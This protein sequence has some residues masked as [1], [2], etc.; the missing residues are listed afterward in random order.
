MQRLHV[1]LTNRCTLECPACPRTTWKN[2]IKRSIKKADLDID[3]FGKFLDCQGGRQIDS[4]TLA[5][6]Y[7]DCIYYPNLIDFIQQFRSRYFEIHTN[8]SYKD[9]TFWK[10]LANNLTDR[11][12]VVFA[13]DGL[14]ENNHLYR[15]NSDWNSIML[16]LD[17][18]ANSPAR[19]KW[20]TI[21]FS[22]N[23]NK[24]NEIKDFAQSKGAEF[25][26][27][28]THRYGD[29]SLIPPAE[30]V[31][32]QFLFK[33]EFNDIEPIEIHPRC[34][35]QKVITCDGYFLPCDWIRNP[36]TFFKSDLWKLR[37]QWYDK[38]SI[39]NINYDQGLEIIT[40]WS[41]LVRKKG[42]ESSP[43]LDVLCKMKCRAECNHNTNTL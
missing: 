20:K 36:M 34:L 6:D 24:L 12:T 30:L 35:N 41:N 9:E 28:K 17:I 19:V 16:G 15:K 32:Q 18:I 1:E 42:L 22:F 7:G 39:L 3:Q 40:Q 31:D 11:D 10:G 38:M 33:T 13:I 37:S 29:N 25:I 14:K 2:T 4:F 26:A 23:Y 5:G 27:E 8:G 43:N 21:V